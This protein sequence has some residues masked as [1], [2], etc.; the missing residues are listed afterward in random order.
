[1]EKIKEKIF[2]ALGEV[3]MCWSEI[4]TGVF[5]TQQAEEIGDKLFIDVEELIN[6]KHTISADDFRHEWEK[7][8]NPFF[9][10]SMRW[11]QNNLIK[12]LEDFQKELQENNEL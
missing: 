1:M 3:S 8:N 12:L 6:E 11:N 5:Q 4:P 10:E 9:P 7:K 2:L